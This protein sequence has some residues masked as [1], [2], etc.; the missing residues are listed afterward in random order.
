MGES[1][2]T[3]KLT[4]PLELMN[5]LL[6]GKELL[7][8][9]ATNLTPT[10]DPLLIARAI[11]ASHDASEL[12]AS[13]I[14]EHVGAERNSKMQ[15][16]MD[17]IAATE[18]ATQSRFP[19]KQFFENLNR[20]RVSFKHHGLLPNSREFHQV[21]ARTEEHVDQACEQ[22]LGMPIRELDTSQLIADATA[23]SLYLEAQQFA[24]DRRYREALEKTAQALY[25]AVAVTPL[26]FRIVPGEADSQTALELTAYGVDPGAFI[27]MQEFLPRKSFLTNEWDWNT[28]EN[29]HP[30]NWREDTISFC[31]D[32]FVDVVRKIQFAA[33]QPSAIQFSFL[34]DDVVT[35]KHDG[36][37]VFSQGQHLAFYGHPE[38]V[39]FLFFK[40]LKLGETIKGRLTPGFQYPDS[41]KWDKSSFE[42]ANIYV[43]AVPYHRW[44]SI[45]S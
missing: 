17:Y 4:L 27:R 42:I 2:S 43:L 25:E 38:T 22:Y 12:I 29:G 15:G 6:I 9:N 32:T 8:T 1:T 40:E 41:Y 5:R 30:G 21:L 45:H 18:K 16:L 13:G 19:G 10:S 31:F 28:R 34:F 11:L 7:L 23:R 14:A 35:A 39:G 33:Y 26:A 36:V 24:R 20:A 3:G 44:R 37:L